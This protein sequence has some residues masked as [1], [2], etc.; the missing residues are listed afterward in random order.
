MEGNK[1]KPRALLIFGAPCSGKTTFSEKFADKF[2]LAC[3]DFAEI[4]EENRLTRKT[5]HLFIK[6]LT[7]TGKTFVMEGCIDTEKSR[8]EIRNIL[9]AAGYE[10][11]LIWIQTDINTIRNRLKNKYRSVTTAREVYDNEVER[12]EAPEDYENPIILS[13]KH[14]FETQCKHVLTGLADA[15]K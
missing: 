11:T 4:K 14:T 15:N 2:D 1:S 10:P 13:G 12:M 5:I 7:R 3:Y 6:L 9:R 8:T